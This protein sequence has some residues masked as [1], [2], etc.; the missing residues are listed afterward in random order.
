VQVQTSH[1]RRDIQGYQ[2]C[3]DHGVFQ[4]FEQKQYPSPAK[5]LYQLGNQ[6][7]RLEEKIEAYVERRNQ[8]HEIGNRK[9][10][11]RFG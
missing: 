1:G 9:L 2:M 6:A 11:Y 4:I 8:F 5:D 3:S 7:T 10:I